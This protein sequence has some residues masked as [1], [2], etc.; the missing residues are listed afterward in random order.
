MLTHQSNKLERYLTALITDGEFDQSA[1][2][3]FIVVE[4]R[5][6][7]CALRAQVGRRAKLEKGRTETSLLHCSN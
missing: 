1:K 2:Q 6:L 4:R 5:V 3:L 7:W